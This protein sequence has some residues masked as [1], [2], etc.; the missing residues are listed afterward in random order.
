MAMPVDIQ[1]G[2]VVRPPRV[3]FETRA[4]EDREASLAAGEGKIVYKDV[5]YVLVT[6]LGSYSEFEGIAVEWIARQ[7]REPYHD[8]LVRAYEAYKIGKEP[9]V[10]GTPLEMCTV[11]TP[12]EIKTMKMVG[13]RAVEDMA[14]WPDG[15]LEMFGM[16]AVRLKQKAQAWLQSATTGAGAQ[17]IDALTAE[18]ETQKAANEGLQEQLRALAARLEAME[19]PRPKLGLKKDAA[20]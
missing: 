6:P 2:Q 4:E 7:Q 8:Q 5:D 10:N 17:K 16:G 3:R 13:V 1:P 15:R 20:A 14:Q 12:A 19:G 18:L 11:F 9:P